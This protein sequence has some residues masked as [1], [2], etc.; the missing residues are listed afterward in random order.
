VARRGQRFRPH[1]HLNTA[2]SA[3]SG[4]RDPCHASRRSK[5]SVSLPKFANGRAPLP[6][7][8]TGGRQERRRQL[9]LTSQFPT[10]KPIYIGCLREFQLP[11]SVCTVHTAQYGDGKYSRWWC[12]PRGWFPH[13]QSCWWLDLNVEQHSKAAASVLSSTGSGLNGDATVGSSPGSASGSSGSSASSGPAMCVCKAK[14]RTLERLDAL[15]VGGGTSMS[16]GGGDVDNRWRRSWQR[17]HW[18]L[19]VAREQRGQHWCV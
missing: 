2:T 18:R 9:G 5:R 8:P 17:C 19:T 16:S 12:S 15:R 13:W 1:A 4:R 3:G 14:R 10:N 6:G 7:L 11:I